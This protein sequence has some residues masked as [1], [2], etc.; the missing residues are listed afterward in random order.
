MSGI[1]SNPRFQ[2]IPTYNNTNNT[3]PETKNNQ[4]TNTRQLGDQP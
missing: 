3:E 2:L 4:H 1:G